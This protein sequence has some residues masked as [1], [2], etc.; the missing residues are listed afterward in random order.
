M[1]RRASSRSARTGREGGV[2]GRGEP[3]GRVRLLG[4]PAPAPLS[5]ARKV[6]SW[7]ACLPSPTT[8]RIRCRLS[9]QG[10]TA[11]P[12]GKKRTKRQSH[13]RQ[14]RG[15]RSAPAL[16]EACGQKPTPRW[17]F[18]HARPHES[19]VSVFVTT[20]EPSEKV[21]CCEVVVRFP[22]RLYFSDGSSSL[23]GLDFGH[24]PSPT[25][26]TY[27]PIREPPGTR[28]VTTILNMRWEHTC[29]CLFCHGH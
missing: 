18:P 20:S 25:Y 6:A 7:Q 26:P 14:G 4:P 11:P 17:A 15:A 9:R 10:S 8:T 29:I 1:P 23:F 27:P 13:Q 3:G 2:P 12:L 19:I 5:R 22:I 16:H 28:R 21:P 24:F